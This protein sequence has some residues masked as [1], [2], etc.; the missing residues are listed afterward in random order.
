[1]DLIDQKNSIYN[2]SVAM[3]HLAYKISH[4]EEEIAKLSAYI[5]E[6]KG[7]EYDTRRMV[8]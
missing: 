5:E 6:I 7:E 2:I 1:M 8:S 4:L 3:D